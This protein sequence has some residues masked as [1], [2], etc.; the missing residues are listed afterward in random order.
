[1]RRLSTDL[2]RPGLTS[3]RLL[4][5][6]YEPLGSLVN[7]GTVLPTTTVPT[8]R[9]LFPSPDRGPARPP[10]R[11]GPLKRRNA[12]TATEGTPSYRQAPSFRVNQRLPRYNLTEST[13]TVRKDTTWGESQEKSVKSRFEG[14]S[15]VRCEELLL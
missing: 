4:E 10:R 8:A 15:G 12:P 6:R 11:E 5:P 14:V 9:S 7:I 1:M 13:E 2:L 3:P